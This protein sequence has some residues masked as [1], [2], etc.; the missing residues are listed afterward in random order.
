MPVSTPF[1]CENKGMDGEPTLAMTVARRCRWVNINAGWY[2]TLV[3]RVIHRR[4]DGP[5]E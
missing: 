1:T 5:H 3:N 4:S 2:N